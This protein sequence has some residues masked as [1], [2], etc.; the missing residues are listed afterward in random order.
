[1]NQNLKFFFGK[2]GC[3]VFWTKEEIGHPAFYQLSVQKSA[4]LMVQ[5]VG[6]LVS[7]QLKYPEYPDDTDWLSFKPQI[8]VFYLA[9]CSMSFRN[10][11]HAAL[12]TNFSKLLITYYQSFCFILLN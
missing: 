12:S 1:M 4:S 9:V 2:H 11:S 10:I 6:A 5:Y 3:C 7:M 8:P